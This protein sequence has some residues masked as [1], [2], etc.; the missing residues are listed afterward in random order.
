MFHIWTFPPFCFLLTKKTQQHKQPLNTPS[1]PSTIRLCLFSGMKKQH[2]WFDRNFQNN[3]SETG[4]PVTCLGAGD[5]HDT[6]AGGWCFIVPGL[7]E[8]Y[9]PC[10]KSEV[11]GPSKKASGGTRGGRS[12][13]KQPM[14]KSKTKEAT[15]VT[16]TFYRAFCSLPHSS[17][18]F[19]VWEGSRCDLFRFVTKLQFSECHSPSPRKHVGLFLSVEKKEVMANCEK[20]GLGDLSNVENRARIILGLMSQKEVPARKGLEIIPIMNEQLHGFR[21]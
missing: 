8:L 19:W 9:Q 15:K 4:F 17:S 6:H 2:K 21:H 12:H 16:D 3:F 7:D 5:P 1:P 20:N 13:F 11:W 14:G 18:L 10:L